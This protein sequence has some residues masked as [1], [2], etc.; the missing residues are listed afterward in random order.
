MKRNELK[1]LRETIHKV[2]HQNENLWWELK[3]QTFDYGY[4][5]FY[6]RQSEFELP[7]RR[8]LLQLEPTAVTE[9]RSEYSLQHPEAQPPTNEQLITY[10]TSLVVEEI[11]RRARI[12][13]DKTENW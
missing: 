13:A 5:C 12:A 3:R 1:I 4:Q 6:P 9:L 7:A 8:H 10:Y 11:V 2:A